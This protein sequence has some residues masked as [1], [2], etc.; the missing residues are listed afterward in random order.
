MAKPTNPLLRRAVYVVSRLRTRSTFTFLGA[1]FTVT[2][3]VLNPTTF[4]ASLLFARLAL[5]RSPSRPSR[6]LELGCGCG[7]TSVL[8][9]RA[10]HHLTAID[11]D[12]QAVENTRANA[13][14]N[15]V[16]IRAVVSDWGSALPESD[17]FDFIATN[18]PFLI[19]EPPAFR[20][21]LYAGPGLAAPRKALAA[22][23]ARLAEKG[24]VLVLTSDRTGREAFLKAVREADM[25]IAH[26]QRHRQW[27]DTYL[28]DVL[29]AA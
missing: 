26:T 19:E 28:E 12:P 16:S 10:G 24:R 20:Q 6:V 14:R 4:R 15:G 25:R 1:S 21:A 11:I 22:A 2:S 23:R 8:L 3:G 7:L 13:S 29:I 5:M 27:L 18:P 9:A 17:A